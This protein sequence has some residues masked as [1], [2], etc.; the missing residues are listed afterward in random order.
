[1]FV[2]LRT[3]S[4]PANREGECGRLVTALHQAV[5]SLDGVKSHWIAQPLSA[6]SL[7][8]GQILWRMTFGSEREAYHAPLLQAWRENIAPLLADTQITG[9]GY[10]VGRSA[11]NQGGSGIW[12]ALVFRV[13]AGNRTDLAQRIDSELLLFPKYIGT[14]RSWALSSVA[15]VEGPKAFTHVWE[16]EFASIDGFTGEYMQHPL[17][18]GLVD[19]YFDSEFPHYVVDPFLIQMVG[20]IDGPVIRPG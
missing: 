15:T 16:Q 5:G 8:A 3:I 19:S 13:A 4:L 6:V 17:H 7:N 2:S 20:E 18:W 1:M 11:G 14:I 9:V 10:R 12:R